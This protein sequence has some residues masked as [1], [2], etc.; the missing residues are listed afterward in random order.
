MIDGVVAHHLEILRGVPRRRIGVGRVE[1]IGEAGAFDRRLLDAVDRLSGAGMPARLEDG[2]HDVD[3]MGELVA[4]AAHVLD[5][6][7]PGDRHALAHAAKMR[8][9]LLEPAEGRVEGPGPAGR[10]VVVG[11]FRAPDVVPLHLH[12]DRQ[13]VE[14]VEEGHFVGRAQRAAFGTRAVVAVDV[15]D[16]RVVELAH[17]LDRLDDAADRIVGIGDI[18]GEDLGLA[19]EELLLLVGRLVPGLQDVAW[20]TGR[21][22]HPAERRRA[23]SGWRRSSRAASP[24]RRRRDAWP[25]SCRPIPWSGGAAR[26]RRPARNRG[27]TACRAGSGSCGSDSRWRHPPCR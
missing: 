24:S 9:D 21:A 2:R 20:A 5:V 23:S 3:H 26:A 17:V 13:H 27:R 7:G 19:D 8:G 16:Q 22:A 18:G 6:A 15:D 11:L 1:G 12:V 10:H 14:A 4:D 25:G